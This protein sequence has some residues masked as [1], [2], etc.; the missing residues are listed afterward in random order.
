MR[1]APLHP[2]GDRRPPQSS[3]RTLMGIAD[4]LIFLTAVLV[5]GVALV[6]LVKLV[7][8]GPPSREILLVCESTAPP[9]PALARPVALEETHPLICRGLIR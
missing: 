2:F 4:K 8:T 5:G 9:A 1:P 6:M 7:V 3:R